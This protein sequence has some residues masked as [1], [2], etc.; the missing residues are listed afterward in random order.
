MVTA[1]DFSRNPLAH[2]ITRPRWIYCSSFKQVFCFIR[3]STPSIWHSS[4]CRHQQRT[5]HNDA[6]EYYQSRLYQLSL[7]T[8]NM[9][10]PER[11][12]TREAGGQKSYAK[13]IRRERGSSKVIL[14]GPLAIELHIQINQMA[15]NFPCLSNQ[16]LTIINA[17]AFLTKPHVFLCRI[18]WKSSRRR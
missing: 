2:S 5:D 18:P 15:Y 1:T 10:T 9:C 8:G 4:P 16:H 13:F 7:C 12:V 11:S 3:L 14:Y 6:T 17:F